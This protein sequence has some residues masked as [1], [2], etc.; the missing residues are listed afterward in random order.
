MEYFPGHTTV[1]ILGAI[2]THM[3]VRKTRPEEFEDR[4]IFMSMF[5]NIDW[6]SNGN[7]K[8]CFFSNS[9]LVIDYEISVGTLVLSRFW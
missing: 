1:E 9:E 8:E 4:I 2:Q 5:N 6:T 3:T 7:Y